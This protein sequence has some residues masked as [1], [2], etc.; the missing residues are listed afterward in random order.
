MTYR[1]DFAP[2]EEPH[3]GPRICASCGRALDG[4]PDED[5][6]GNAGEP[7]C[8]ECVRSTNFT[9]MDYADGELDDVIG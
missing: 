1:V 5:P 2:D 4:D 8:G 6:I 7:Q 3:E 9:A